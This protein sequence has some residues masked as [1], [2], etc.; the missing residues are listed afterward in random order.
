[1]IY[2][3]S[4]FCINLY[5]IIKLFDPGVERQLR[6]RMWV[7]QW[8]QRGKKN[9]CNNIFKLIKTIKLRV[10]RLRITCSI[11]VFHFL[12][13]TLF[14]QFSLNIFFNLIFLNFNL[15]LQLR[16]KVRIYNYLFLVVVNN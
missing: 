15:I 8:D 6:T 10:P 12:F 7:D 4:G 11:F 14:Y 9:V 2:V 3:E 5:I 1:M 16:N 13:H